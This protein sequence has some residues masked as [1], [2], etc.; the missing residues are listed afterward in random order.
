MFVCLFVFCF[1][2]ISNLLQ[3]WSET[4]DAVFGERKKVHDASSSE[5][6]FDV[7]QMHVLTSSAVSVDNSN[8]YLDIGAIS[9]VSA[10]Q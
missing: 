3:T 1:F 7:T 6:A 10:F 9:M 2:C 5:M 8:M 4:K